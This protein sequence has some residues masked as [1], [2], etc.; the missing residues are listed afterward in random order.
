M[1]YEKRLGVFVKV[2]EPGTVKTRLT[3]PLS[4]DEACRLYTA[5]VTDLFT[6]I[7]RLKK[8]RGTVFYTGGDPEGISDYIPDS[9]ELIAQKGETLGE[10]LAAAFDHLLA[11]EGRNRA[12]VR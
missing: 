12:W 3:P 8:V 9:Y 7:G 10:R 2:P 11:G 6:R 5:F 4:G 1:A